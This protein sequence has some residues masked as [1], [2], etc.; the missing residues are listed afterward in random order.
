LLS[1]CILIRTFH[2]MYEEVVKVLS[3]LKG[4]ERVFPVLGRYDVVA[5]VEASD[6]EELGSTIMRMG[7][8]NGVVFT[9][10]LVE[11]KRG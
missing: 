5:D 1:A 8:I 3:Q 4:V 10:T 6:F 7:R 11:I 2:G 9:E